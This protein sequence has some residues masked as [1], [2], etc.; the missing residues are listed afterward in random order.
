[1]FMQALVSL[2][3]VANEAGPGKDDLASELDHSHTLSDERAISP[4]HEGVLAQQAAAHCAEV[5]ELI[6]S[7]ED[8]IDP[9]NPHNKGWPLVPYLPAQAGQ[10]NICINLQP[11]HLKAILKHA[12]KCVIRECAFMHGYMP[13][14]Q[15][16]DILVNILISSA[17]KL[18]IPYY[19]EWVQKDTLIQRD[20][21]DLVG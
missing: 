4:S 2:G 13:V 17:G 20:V 15:Q 8:G 16:T 3:K 7:N 5:I 1:M 6:D 19:T 10:C 18:N 14:N 12:V 9:D 21:C 11:V